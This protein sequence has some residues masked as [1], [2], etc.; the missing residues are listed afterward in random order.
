MSINIVGTPNR[1]KI[2]LTARNK[3]GYMGPVSVEVQGYVNRN[4]KAKVLE[5]NLRDGWDWNKFTPVIV[6]KFP[7]GEQRLL[8]GDHRRHMFRLV[9]PSEKT[10][11]AYF[12][13]VKDMQEYHTLF[14]EINWSV[15]ANAKKSE[16]F[17]HQCHAGEAN[18][19]RI[20]K[21][22]QDCSLS[23]CGSNDAGGTIGA[24]AG[25]SINVGAFEKCLKTF[26]NFSD[27][28]S[29]RAHYTRL[30][31]AAYRRAWP[32]DSEV[33]AELFSALVMLYNLYPEI[34]SGN[35]IQTDW[36]N[37]FE[38]ALCNYSAKGKASAWK[39]LGG[40]VHHKAYQSIALG[41]L[42]E[43]QDTTGKTK[44]STKKAKL[45]VDLIKEQLGLN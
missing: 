40:N 22:L 8:D 41:L 36:D 29:A 23:V 6:A 44:S 27:S 4:T 25:M 18:A 34:Y 11:P 2:K 37:W 5:K 3:P 12:I 32:S 21:A 45:K 17:V 1:S 24:P 7:G 43:F 20:E 16:V 28:A 14:T 31:A 15:R 26:D 10:M 33:K 19:K 35:G 30:A 38:A 13:D 42:R 39:L 9:F